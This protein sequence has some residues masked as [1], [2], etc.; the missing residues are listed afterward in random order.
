MI[1]VGVIG[2]G[3][4]GPN[5]V[6]VFDRAPDSRVVAVCDRSPARLT[7]VCAQRPSLWAT[8][9]AH[10]LIEHRAV[11]AV[12]VATPAATHFA[13][14][15]A[16]LCAG[17][18]VLVEK[19]IATTSDD[20]RQLIDAAARRRRVLMVDHTYV[21]AGAV[22]A[23]RELVRAGAIGAP[24]SYRSVRSN[25]QHGVSDEGVLWDLAVHDLAIIDY[26]F[27]ERPLAVAAS[28]PLPPEPASLTLHFNGPLTARI[29]TSWYAAEKR[30]HIDVLGSHGRLQYDDL[31]S[32]A[33]LRL[34][35]GASRPVEHGG[36]EPLARVA[37]HFL[38]CVCSGA[39]PL[40]DG[41]CGLRTVQILEA[42]NRSLADRGRPA[43][44]D[45]LPD[46]ADR[47]PPAPARRSAIT[48]SSP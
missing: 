41:A 32:T 13:L 28:A 29:E 11:D 38:S 18:H 37:A 4:W 24:A 34:E 12:I 23:L 17:K 22:Q 44:I 9:D 2:L 33:K 36:S 21:Y 27:T 30:R 39:H 6:R 20:A 26:V 35:N 10:A 15:H 3:H 48:S 5:L 47:V 7:A 45:A 43:P 19:P 42:A 16:A 31:A 1:G 46:D 14:A 25:Q 40:T 8:T